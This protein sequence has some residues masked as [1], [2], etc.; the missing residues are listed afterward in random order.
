MA[1]NPLLAVFDLKG[2]WQG[3]SKGQYQT[4][5]S[6]AGLPAPAAGYLWR[7]KK[8][9][10]SRYRNLQG[11]TSWVSQAGEEIPGDDLNVTNGPDTTV[12]GGEPDY[13]ITAND[14]DPAPQGS[15]IWKETMVAEGYSDWEQWEIPTA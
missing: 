6:V 7:R 14:L 12:F 4:A 9:I 11:Y 13:L 15:G 3:S 10:S 1:Y 2:D 8:F 5:Q